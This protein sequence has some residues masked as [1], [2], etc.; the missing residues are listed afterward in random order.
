MTADPRGNAIDAVKKLATDCENF[1]F[2]SLP[3]QNP[4]VHKHTLY[5]VSTLDRIP[6]PFWTVAL[7]K[8]GDPLVLDAQ[9]PDAWNR[10]MLEEKPSLK[11]ASAASEYV[12]A[13]LELAVGRALL[14]S[15][16]LPNE[17]DQVTKS[18]KDAP[19]TSPQIIREKEI[20]S[21]SFYA[22]DARGILQLWDLLVEPS[23]KILKV[24]VREF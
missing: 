2:F 15:K 9:R 17:L 10:M 21:I 6:P 3:T 5:F 19:K 8:K 12:K 24:D 11:T 1:L 18:T 22:K 20:L 7:P 4:L 16:L 14:V 13:F 23:G